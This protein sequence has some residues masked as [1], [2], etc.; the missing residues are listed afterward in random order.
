MTHIRPRS[1]AFAAL[2]LLLAGGPSLASAQQVFLNET[3]ENVKPAGL[4]VLRV[5]HWTAQGSAQVGSPFCPSAQL[6]A[7]GASQATACS[8][9]AFGMDII[10]MSGAQLPVI[11]ANIAAVANCDNVVK[12]PGCPILTGQIGGILNEFV[13][14]PGFPCAGTTPLGDKKQFLG[15]SLPIIGVVGQF[16]PDTPMA[17]GDPD[18]A[19]GIFLRTEPPGPTDPGFFDLQ[20]LA[21][22]LLLGSQSPDFT[23]RFRLPFKVGPAGNPEHF[24]DGDDERGENAF[25][26]ADDG[27][28]M[29]VRHHEFALGFPTVRADVTFI[30][31]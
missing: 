25:Y 3:V 21:L 15:P 2:A 28:L 16:F 17:D 5:S 14:F 27:Q 20:P 18:H 6:A 4:P 26:L 11:W 12:A 13:C 24:E 8:V 23:A 31:R 7:A 29:K 1:W 22:D 9:T 10:D 30:R 19:L